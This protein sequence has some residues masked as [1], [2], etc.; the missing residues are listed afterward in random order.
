MKL[1]LFITQLEKVD[2]NQFPCL[3]ERIE[4]AAGN[5]N[6][7]KS[8]YSKTRFECRFCEEDCILEF[9]NPFHLVNKACKW[10]SL[11]WK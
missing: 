8:S 4:F 5:G 3:K 7:R 11:T 6:L 1:K 2:M 9:I 10:N